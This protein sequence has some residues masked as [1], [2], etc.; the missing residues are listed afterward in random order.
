[1]NQK[2]EST[3]TDS[4]RVQAKI[5]R[6]IS[7]YI[8]SLDP[9]VPLTEPVYAINWFNTKRLWLYNFYNLLAAVSV[10]NVGGKLFF[11]G[12]VEEVLVGHDSQRRD[13]LLI[14]HYPGP[15]HFLTLLES[16]YFKLVSIFRLIS[17]K[18]FTFGFMQRTDSRT[19][20][21]DNN[22]GKVYAI[23]HYQAE[24]GITDMLEKIIQKHSGEVYFAG[25]ISSLLYSRDNQKP[26]EQVPCLMTG[27]LLFRADTREQIDDLINNSDYQVIVQQTTS[28]F[29]ATLERIQ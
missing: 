19:V 10:K 9:S 28:S 20:T 25:Q 13:V 6:K 21:A 5:T 2:S 22:K 14:V 26:E 3:S 23:H 11:K 15:R 24:K 17:V 27:L 7:V 18:K 16:T 1:M 8:Q 12:S 4:A 29:I